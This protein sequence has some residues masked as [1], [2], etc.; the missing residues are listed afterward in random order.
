[1]SGG[2]GTRD[3]DA[4][5]EAHLAA[6]DRAALAAFVA[7]LYAARGRAVERADGVLTAGTGASATHV[8]VAGP[9]GL[10]PWGAPS[11]GQD[12]DVVAAADPERA[13]ALADRAD[14][15]AL[16]AAGMVEMARYG[17]PPGTLATLCDRH[18]GAPPTGLAPPRGE[19][20]RATVGGVASK[21]SPLAVVAALAVVV[22]AL[23]VPP[24]LA[25]ETAPRAGGMDPPDGEAMTGTPQEPTT[26]AGAAAISGLGP[27]GVE[28]VT[29]LAAAHEAALA[30]ESYAL[31]MD[32]YRP[33]NRTA[34]NVRVQ[35]DVDAAVDGERSLVTV[36]EVVGDERTRE[37]AVYG[38]GSAWYVARGPSGNATY[39]RTAGE[40]ARPPTVPAPDTVASLLVET[41]LDASETALSDRVVEA[42]T[43]YYEV[44][45]RGAP[46]AFDQYWIDGYEARALVAP[47]GLVTDLVVTYTVNAADGSFQ[48]RLEFTYGGVGEATVAPPDWYD[49]EFGNDSAPPTGPPGGDDPAVPER[50]VAGPPKRQI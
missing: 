22:G 25:G 36:T 49:R 16:D 26:I 7:D 34:G 47:S 40:G 4:R 28:N 42:R 19:R 50:S 35:H 18:L 2:S 3:H 38:D 32:T 15:R 23:T 30:G 1:M 24:F 44:V 48:V 20:V 21:V 27:G 41:Y 11:P 39:E 43:T 13:A 37:T 14:A 5:V 33:R 29:R 31:W 45:A 8:L 12:V 9:P 17:A 6:L 10:T 46:P